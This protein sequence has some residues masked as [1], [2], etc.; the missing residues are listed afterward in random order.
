MWYIGQDVVSL[1]NH[2]E[3][4][5]KEGDVKTIYG[6]KQGCCS[7]EYLDV[8]IKLNEGRILRCGICGKETP[9]NGIGWLSEKCFKP[10]DE[11]SDISEIL[12]HLEQENFEKM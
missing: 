6:L 1:I 3:C 7:K 9:S 11:L 4:D 12:E 5:L 8:G 2:K 10:L